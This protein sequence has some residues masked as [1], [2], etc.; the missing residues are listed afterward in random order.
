MPFD[1]QVGDG[2]SGQDLH[3][4]YPVLWHELNMRALN[5]VAGEGN[6]LCFG[7]SG[8]TGDQRF[9]PVTWG[10]DQETS[11]ERDDGIAT[12]R[13]IGVG[14]GLSG[15]GRYG[16]D[17]AGFSS[18]WD[19]P[20]TEELYLRWITMGAFEPVMRTHDGLAEDENWH[21]EAD[22]PTLLTFR[23]YARL[24]MRLQ[25]FWELLDRE[26]Q[27]DGLPL[28]RHSVLVHPN[29]ATLRDAP[30]QHFLGD[31]LVVAPVLNPG[32]LERDVVLPAGTWYGLL[33]GTS[34]TLE[35]T[36]TVTAAAPM[37]EIPV[38]ARAGSMLPM[39]DPE[40][41]TSHPARG[42]VVDMGDRADRIDLT[43]FHGADGSLELVGGGTFV[44]RSTGDVADGELSVDGVPTE[45]DEPCADA[46][47]WGCRES[48]GDGEAVYRVDW[49]G[50]LVGS[51]WE[52]DV[53]EGRGRRGVLT[54]RY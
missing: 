10:G 19:G 7:R 36:G 14:L 6:G 25:P 47:A 52:L 27:R 3:N 33:D 39:L 29:N 51:G 15:V 40:V 21:F 32:L 12:A 30:D 4:A 18:Q 1:A 9:T 26:Y 22:T 49:S 53:A 20:S 5:E 38:F 44:L 24:H 2:R 28:M 50:D 34:H 17:I 45:W 35:T 11:W 54:L 13:E 41:V 37:T 8:W 43:V 48:F 46:R 16:S 23:R 31:D 42:D